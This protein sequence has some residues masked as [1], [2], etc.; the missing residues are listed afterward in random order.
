VTRAEVIRPFV[1]EAI[2][3]YLGIDRDELEVWEDGTIPIRAGS[4]AVSVRL[5]DG[6]G[7]RSIL[8]VFAPLVR[9]V[10]ASPELFERLNEINAAL[11]FA[12]VFWVDDQIFLAMEL[13]A[14]SL[15][16]QQISHA[17]SLVSLA[18]DRWD[19][20]LA[21]TFGG[22]TPFPGDPSEETEGLTG[23]T[24]NAPD[25]PSAGYI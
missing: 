19:D 23:S 24:P 6:P 25:D 18:A 20:V 1:E 17:V 11:S 14:G 21:R 16:R 22:D 12:R 5:D 13:L 10:H 8:Q 3:G 2:S 4:T 9:D 15:D 7:E